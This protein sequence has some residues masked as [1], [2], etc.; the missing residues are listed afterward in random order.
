MWW[1]YLR[2]ITNFI[3]LHTVISLDMILTTIFG[4]IQRYLQLYRFYRREGEIRGVFWS[5]QWR[6]ND[7]DVVSN[8]SFKIV[9]SVVYSSADQR[10]PQS[11]A[12]LAF[13]EGKSPA[14]GEFPSQRA[15][16]AENVSIWWR[17]HVGLI[18]VHGLYVVIVWLYSISCYIWLPRDH[19]LHTII[20][21][22]ASCWVLNNQPF[23]VC[24]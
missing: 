20:K 5:L 2:H 21:K 9:Y 8:T 22:N 1:K 23:K 18:L 15:S 16:N 4:Y 11:S 13:C 6:R 3:S 17:N 19:M 7:R 14:T 10:K 12:S 24:S